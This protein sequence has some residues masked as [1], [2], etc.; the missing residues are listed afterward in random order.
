[1]ANQSDRIHD[2]IYGAI[3]AYD[4][5]HVSYDTDTG[6]RTTS[7]V[8]TENPKTVLVRQLGSQFIQ[9]MRERRTPRLAERENWGWVAHVAFDNQ[10][11]VEEFE[12][13]QLDAPVLLPRTAELDQQV[14]IWLIETELEHPPEQQSATGTRA[15]FR[16]VA[17]LSRR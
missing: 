17:Q 7:A 13:S 16:Y 3:S 8:D 11:S 9:A 14:T 15:I 4:F 6:L 1:M 10:V 5:P 2:S 12:L